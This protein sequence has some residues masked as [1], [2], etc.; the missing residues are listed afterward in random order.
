MRNFFLLLVFLN[1][2][3]CDITNQIELD[4]KWIITKMIYDGKSVYPESLSPVIR[5]VYNGNKKS[6]SITFQVS[7]STMILPGF[8]SQQLKTQ[9]T[10]DKGKLKID[11]NDS[12]SESELTNKIFSGT[13]DLTF[14]NKE[15]TLKLKSDK[16]YITLISFEEIISK[17]VGNR[18]D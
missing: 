2:S 12:S 11:A 8:Q 13:Y 10:F 1:F 16:T 14:S 18:F 4:G 5:I 7:D 15:K 3:S 9:F 17:A 6:E